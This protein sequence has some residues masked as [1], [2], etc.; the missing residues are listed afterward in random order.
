M[1]R[2]LGISMAAALLAVAATACGSSF[3]PSTA[4]AGTWVL[5]PAGVP[6]SGLDFTVADEGGVVSG[7]GERLIEAGPTLTFSVTGIQSGLSVTLHFDYA[8]GAPD[9]FTG[10]MTDATHL[11]GTLATGGGSAT[12]QFVRSNPS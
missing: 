10:V 12:V 7:T 6:G 1:R 3:E 5:T 11:K 2:P 8:S 9:Q 4:L